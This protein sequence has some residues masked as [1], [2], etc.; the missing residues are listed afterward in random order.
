M[1]IEHLRVNK[2]YSQRTVSIYSDSI[3]ELY[4][5]IS[6]AQDE[7]ERDLLTSQQIRAYTADSLKRGLSPKSVNLRLSAISS[8]CNYLVKNGIIAFNPVKRIKRPKESKKLPEFFTSYAMESYFNEEIDNHDLF[9]LRDRVV[10]ETLYST[11]IRRGELAGLRISDWDRERGLFRIKGKGDKIREVPV[12]V[13]L[14]GNLGQYLN[15]MS[16]YYTDNPGNMLFLTD[17]GEPMYLS[18]VNK[19]VKRELSGKEGFSGKKS[20]HVL[21]HSFAT[22]L[23]NNG[24]DLNSIKEVLGHS[25]LSA[26]Q[27]YTHNSFENLKK[28][29]L[30]AHPRAKKGG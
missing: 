3:T 15:L 27:I 10:I 20:P 1:F 21:R 28:T 11:G 14:A 25:S 29:F 16:E 18:F 4:E 7:S 30:T 13:T 17:N 26:T 5:F 2:R 24:A 6:P 22:H 23:L 19:I 12:P 9:A 8:Y